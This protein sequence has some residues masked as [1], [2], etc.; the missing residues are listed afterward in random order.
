[1][2]ILLGCVMISWGQMMARVGDSLEFDLTLRF[3]VQH[4]YDQEMLPA[5]T[6]VLESVG[7]GWHFLFTGGTSLQW[8][9]GLEIWWRPKTACSR[10]ADAL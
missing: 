1:M 7:F 2:R 6:L 4:I 3:E 8:N 5:L 10:L 9:G